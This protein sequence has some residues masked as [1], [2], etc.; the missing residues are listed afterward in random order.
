[1]QMEL[2]ALTTSDDLPPDTPLLGGRIV[3]D[4]RIGRGGAATVYAATTSDGRDVALKI[5]SAAYA[6]IPS[7]RQRFRNEVATAQHLAD[8]PG[9]V[10][11][12]AIGELPELGGRPYIT[13]PLVK[14]CSLMMLVGQ[15][16]VAEA[17]ALVR[18]VARIVAD[19]HAR[20]IVHRDIKPGNVI[21]RGEPGH[22]V[23][24][25]I[26]FGLAYS[27]GAA[28]APVTAGLTT[29]HELP[30]T[31]HYMAPEQVLG[32][33]PDPRF[34]VY[35]LGVTLY[36]VLTGFVP[37]HE[38]APADAARRKCDPSLPPLSIMGKVPGL[39]EVLER[40]I[41]AA[42]ERE[43]ERRTAS[44]ARLAEHL[45][46]ALAE[47]Q[48]SRVEPEWARRPT[49]PDVRV[50]APRAP[51]QPSRA[52][53]VRWWPWALGAAVLAALLG[54]GV[55]LREPAAM[56]AAPDDE[57]EL[58]QSKRPESELV[59][60]SGRAEP[61]GGASPSP[62]V[63]IAPAPAVD[64]PASPKTEVE[65]EP[66]P[67]VPRRKD[68]APAKRRPPRQAVELPCPD[69]AAK[70]QAARR[71]REWHEV[72]ALTEPSRCWGDDESRLRLQIQ[73]LVELRRYRECAAFRSTSRDP[74]VV[75]FA[76]TC[77]AQLHEE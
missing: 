11:P 66:E 6:A 26:D 58:V 7:A 13:M 18:D 32:A 23:P 67:A 33:T 43:P 16:P 75:R 72:L 28:N 42:L 9:V 24:Y 29:A 15:L 2:A 54:A 1:M 10:T 49:Q 35:A 22:R 19:V 38:L 60:A 62:R 41:D 59:Q 46:G 40:A 70:A 74:Q 34:D 45:T 56:D 25:L 14:G 65:V 20:G 63:Q 57:P 8:H 77:A 12:Y 27:D 53:A 52:G 31:K 51:L 39:P 55:A 30:G 76:K 37:L 44:A 73:A 61:S 21:V 48:R 5:M 47:L 36:E 64:P 68:K 3:V 69:L 17:V 71:R 50:E 4:V